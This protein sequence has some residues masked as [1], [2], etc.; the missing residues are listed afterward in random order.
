M[1]VLYESSLSHHGVKGQ[2]W[3]IQN[4][5]PY[6]LKNKAV[7]LSGKDVANRIDYARSMEQWH[8]RGKSDPRSTG[9]HWNE[10][11]KLDTADVT[12]GMDFAYKYDLAT[13]QDIGLAD[14][15]IKADRKW[16]DQIDSVATDFINFYGF[17][18]L[19]YRK[20]V[21]WD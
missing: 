5:P 21:S 11:R 20:Q 14:K 10:V 9:K 4:G 12:S 17:N 19:P 3:G 13:L 1:K 2:K 6:P 18:T 16:E 15:K 7:K 8:S